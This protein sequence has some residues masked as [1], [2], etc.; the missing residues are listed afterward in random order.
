VGLS[1]G[2]FKRWLKEALEVGYLTLYGS[3]VTGTWK[4]ELP[5]LGPW[6][7]GTKGCGD[8]ATISIGALLGNLEGGSSTRDF[9]RWM[10]GALG[11]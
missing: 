2:D 11:M 3:S 1:T 5:C 6:R 8:G 4:G 7:I 9:E 10:K